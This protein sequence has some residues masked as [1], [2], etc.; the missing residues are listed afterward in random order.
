MMPTAATVNRLDQ[1]GSPEQNI[2]GKT[3]GPLS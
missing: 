1:I 2:Q 3:D